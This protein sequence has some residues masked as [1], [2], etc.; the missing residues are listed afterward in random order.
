MATARTI[1]LSFKPTMSNA[2]RQR[3][4]TFDNHSSEKIKF[5]KIL[6]LIHPCQKRMKN[7]NAQ[8]MLIVSMYTQLCPCIR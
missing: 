2:Q 3:F 4:T 8:K 1:I 7:I 6:A 5:Q